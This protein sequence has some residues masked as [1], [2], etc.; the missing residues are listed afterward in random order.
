MAIFAGLFPIISLIIT[1]NIVNEIQLM[2]HSFEDVVIGILI[3]FI[4]SI[5]A[6]IIKGAS[7]YNMYKLSN[8]LTYGINYMLMKKCGDLSLEKFEQS[9]TYNSINRLEQEIGIKPYQTLQSLLSV[10]SNI[11]S[12]VS[13]LVLLATWNIWIDIFLFLVSLA[14]LFGEVYIGNK[15]FLIRYSRSEQE[16]KAWYYSYLMTHDTSLKK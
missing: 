12:Y 16:R 7:S 8:Q 2:Q 11:I 10:V 6:T 3:F 5:I 4:A 13:A 15:E 14:M 9:E 1:Q